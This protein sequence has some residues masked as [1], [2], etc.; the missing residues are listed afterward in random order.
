MLSSESFCQQPRWQKKVQDVPFSIYMS[1]D[2]L[3]QTTVYV[4]V[5]SERQTRLIET[6]NRLLTTLEHIKTTDALDPFMSHSLIVHETLLDAKSVILSLRHQLYSSL[7]RV[8]EYAKGSSRQRGKT[9]LEDLTIQL[10][11]VSQDIDAMTANAE[12]QSMIIRKLMAGHERYRSDTHPPSLTNSLASTT[13]ALQYLADSVESQR[14][15]LL[16]YK[17]RKDIAMNLVSTTL[18][19]YSQVEHR[20]TSPKV[21]NLVTQQDAFTST[22]IASAAKADGNSMKV[23]AALTMVFLPGTFLS[24]VFGMSMIKDSVPWWLYVALTL[25]LTILVFAV[26]W[27]WKSCT[28]RDY[29]WKIWRPLVCQRGV[30]V[31]MS[32]V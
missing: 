9:E 30:R 7:Q 11:V 23:I 2:L 29:R 14:R 32:N 27:T 5:C 15:W 1:H 31:E 4:V 6:R 18:R 25:P 3:S 10:H 17:A 28:Q 26:W 13:D 8:D 20:L 21:Y 12:M 24:S 19:P 16:S 22:T